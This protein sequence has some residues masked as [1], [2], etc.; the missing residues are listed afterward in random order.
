M[1]I[2][3]FHCKPPAPRFVIFIAIVTSFGL[4]PLEFLP[5]SDIP[6]PAAFRLTQQLAA[7]GEYAAESSVDSALIDARLKLVIPDMAH[8]TRERNSDDVRMDSY[9]FRINPVSSLAIHVGALTVSG[10]PARAKAPLFSLSS[11]FHEP[12][13]PEDG[14]TFGLGSAKKTDNGAI[15]YRTAGSRFAACT[16]ALNNP[17]DSTWI[18]ASKE[19]RS[20][21]E[22][23]DYFVL[24]LFSG[25]KRI[26]PETETS[27][28][29][30]E[31]L[32]PDTRMFIPG[33]EGLFRK[34][35]IGGTVTGFGNFASARKPAALSRSELFIDNGIFRLSGGYLQE[36]REFLD[37]DG[38]SARILS[39]FFLSPQCMVRET[40]TFGAILANDTER[41]VKCYHENITAWTGGGGIKFETT[42]FRFRLQAMRKEQTTSI[43]ASVY[44]NALIF[45]FLSASVLSSCEIPGSKPD[46]PEKS[47]ISGK[48][49]IRPFQNRSK[50][51][52]ASIGYN[53]CFKHNTGSTDASD[54]NAVHKGSLEID[55][56]F[57]TRHASWRCALQ[58]SIATDGS[59]PEG[60]IRIDLDIS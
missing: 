20:F 34:G 36:D 9:A 18:L 51:V 8:F 16:T 27:W 42:N 56:F 39:R 5:A 47:A 54:F 49:G 45:R 14:P 3:Y 52:A 44:K 55:G 1:L 30:N 53:G 32:G 29:V 21:S 35:P 12:V 28:F 7:T 38:D 33:A 26:E 37:F 11:P 22:E 17:A 6:F 10:L 24:S 19:F 40:W 46:I 25:I 57:S 58:G 48:V 15:E 43:S 31:P 60:C 41:G 2:S 59:P 4:F 50:G 13:M 23:N